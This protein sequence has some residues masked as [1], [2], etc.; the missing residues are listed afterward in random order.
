LDEIIYGIL[1]QRRAVANATG[2]APNGA[3]SVAHD[4]LSRLLAAQDED[5]SRMTDVQLRDELVT[6]ILAGHETTALALTYSFYLLAQHPQ[7]LDRLQ[8]ELSDVLAGREPTVA[9]LPRLVYADAVIK[10][11]MRLYPPAWAIAR[12]AVGDCQLGEFYVPAGTQ[13]WLSQWVVH[14]DPRWW[15][16]AELFLPERWADD[17]IR[18]LP[19]GTYFPFGDGPRVCIGSQF[20]TTE[21]VLL[22]T[23]IAQRYRLELV[24]GPPIRPLPSIT[25]RPDRP[26]R[27]ILHRS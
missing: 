8:S 13:I 11:A 2:V 9:D 10:E 1:R 19:R 23:T 5:G 20:A 17:L 25:L 4:L 18:R 14:R 27:M 7:A 15:P 6:L 3:G 22:L 21:A 24:P 16:D 26:L 12:E